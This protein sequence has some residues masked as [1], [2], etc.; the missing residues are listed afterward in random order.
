MSDVLGHPKDPEIVL[1]A[2]YN[3]GGETTDPSLWRSTDG[4][5]SWE[6]VGDGFA[7]GGGV[8][9]GAYK[10]SH[11]PNSDWLFAYGEGDSID[12]SQDD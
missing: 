2:L 5:E 12:Y 11:E 3:W 8:Y 1:S 7:L 10:L 6:S 9:A 4:G